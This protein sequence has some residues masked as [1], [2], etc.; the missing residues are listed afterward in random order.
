VAFFQE[1][2][3]AALPRRPIE[4]PNRFELPLVNPNLAHVDE[5]TRPL[6]AQA[7]RWLRRRA[8]TVRRWWR[9]G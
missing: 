3:D 5:R 4:L 1:L 8:G 6:P 2:R 7:L 9:G